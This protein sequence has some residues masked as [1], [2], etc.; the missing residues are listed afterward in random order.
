MQGWNLCVL[1]S[2]NEF[3]KVWLTV[4]AVHELYL[5]VLRQ[6]ASYCIVS[7]NM[8]FRVLF[9]SSKL[10][11]NPSWYME[12]IGIAVRIRLSIKT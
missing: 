6:D 5:F 12:G 10:V 3:D 1:K 7:P 9:I 8:L 11:G 4:Y 2:H